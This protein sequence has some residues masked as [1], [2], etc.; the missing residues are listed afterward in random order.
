MHPTNL[1]DMEIIGR[2]KEIRVLQ[3]CEKSEK[4]EFIG[5][6]GR[7]RVGKTFLI[8]EFYGDRLTFHVSG[9]YGAP[10]QE[11]LETFNKA[12]KKITKKE[13]K[14]P[15]NWNE[16]FDRL[17]E[18]LEKMPKKKGKKKILFFDELPWMATPNSN[19]LAALEHFWNDFAAWEH[20]IILII[21]GSATAWM[22]QKVVDNH[23]GLHNRLTKRIHLQPFTLAETEKFLTHKGV[24][25]NRYQITECYMMMGGIPYY[26]DYIPT[27]GETPASA[28]DKLF[29]TEGGVLREEYGNLYASLFSNHAPHIAIVETLAK[30]NCGMTRKEIAEKAHLHENGVLTEYLDNLEACGFI[31]KYNMYGMTKKN[32]IYQLI[33]PYTLFYLRFI[34]EDISI[35]NNHWSLMLDNPAKRAWEGYAFEM[36]CMMHI[37]E[38]RHALNFGAVSCTLSSWRAKAT[39]EH[40]GAQIDIVIERRDKVINICEVKFVNDKLTITEAYEQQLRNKIEAFRAETGTK[41]ALHLT[42]IT[43]YGVKQNKHSGII[44]SQVTLDGLFIT[45]PGASQS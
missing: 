26:L 1:F 36:V 30:K 43:T 23:G 2:E 12:L 28:I 31:R 19:M 37:D 33:D 16:A 24:N 7:R 4:S 6:F 44:T 10:M 42:M 35:G 9:K 38:I 39:E 17:Q 14:A 21:C 15:Q 5:L 11:Q 25:W 29:F 41:A 20:D 45:I 3:E 32:T 27:D 18:Q 13:E 34:K 40:K 22:V 8:R